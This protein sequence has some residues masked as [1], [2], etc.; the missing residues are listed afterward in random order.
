MKQM[1]ER[2]IY[3]A[4]EERFEKEKDFIDAIVK[5]QKIES[6]LNKEMCDEMDNLARRIDGLE[7]AL[8]DLKEFYEN[9]ES[10]FIDEMRGE[11]DQKADDDELQQVRSLVDSIQGVVN[12]HHDLLKQITKRLI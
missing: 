9:G 1:I 5:H 3:W 7:E 2:I 6:I 10:E 11:V 12:G 4:L 8:S